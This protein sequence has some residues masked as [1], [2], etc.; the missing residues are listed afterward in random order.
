MEPHE[1]RKHGP[2]R[3]AIGSAQ[4]SGL[5]KGLAKLRW[6]QSPSG[7][8]R[9]ILHRIMLDSD[10]Q[11]LAA[12]GQRADD[13]SKEGRRLVRTMQFSEQDEARI[14]LLDR[15]PAWRQCAIFIGHRRLQRS[16]RAVLIGLGRK[17]GWQSEQ[18]SGHQ[19]VQFHHGL[20]AVRDHDAM[21]SARYCNVGRSLIGSVFPQGTGSLIL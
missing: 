8:K 4:P 10:E 1:H 20:P 12:H 3:Y 21:L 18:P 6:R 7:L 19:Y 13:P 16:G 2:A 9:G 5:A 17:C 11:S 15:V 14:A